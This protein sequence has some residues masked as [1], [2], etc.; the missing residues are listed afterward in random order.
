MQEMHWTP[1]QVA[2]LDSGQIREYARQMSI[3]ARLDELRARVA[4]GEISP[5][6]AEAGAQMIV[7]EG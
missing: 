2:G 7:E 4:Q 3:D 5:E 1:D 6:A